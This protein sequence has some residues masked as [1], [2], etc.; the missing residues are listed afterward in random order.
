MIIYLNHSWWISPEPVALHCNTI[1][2][3]AFIVVVGS[4]K[5]TEQF[6]IPAIQFVGMLLVKLNNIKLYIVIIYKIYF[7]AYIILYSLLLLTYYTWYLYIQLIYTAYLS[8]INIKFPFKHF[9]LITIFIV[10]LC[11]IFYSIASMLCIKTND[12]QNY[13][14]M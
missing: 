14:N 13:M 12:G 7:I 4:V 1:E 2:D 10:L 3:P 5:C 6:P 9:N 8:S 11:V